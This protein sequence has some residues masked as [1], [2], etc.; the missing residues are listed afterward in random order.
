VGFTGRV[1]VWDGLVATPAGGTDLVRLVRALDDDVEVWHALKLGG[2]LEPWATWAEGA[3]VF[4]GLPPVAVYGGTTTF[5]AEGTALTQLHVAKDRWSA[6]V[7]GEVRDEAPDV[8]ALAARL[9]SAEDERDRAA[10]RRVSR[11]HAER[12]R[13]SLAVLVACTD[14]E[15]GAVIASPTTS[16]PEVVG[17]GRQFD[18]R[19]SWLRDSSVAIT[20]ASLVGNQELAD[21]YVRF[22]TQLGSERIL[23][24]PIRSVDGEL[25]PD[26]RVVPDVEGWGVSQ[27][28]RVG[29]DAAT[30]LQ[31][32]V[33]G[34]VL[35]AIVTVRRTRRRLDRD[36]WDIATQ[37]ADRAAD[38]SAPS[39]GIWEIRDQQDYVSGDIGR[40]LALDRALQLGHRLTGARSRGRW[41]RARNDVRARV[42]GALRDDGSL[43]QIYGRPGVD[44]SALVLVAFD[45]VPARDP[46]AAALVDATIRTL[47]AGPLLY[48]Y[49]PDGRDGFDAGEAPFVPASWW[50]VTAL[51]KLG[52]PDAQNRADELCRMLPV[53]QPEEFD[54][55]RREAL[56]N[57]PLL[58]SH[59]E[60][61]R[62]LF[63]LDRQRG[64][65]RRLR[66]VWRRRR[67]A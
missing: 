54:P 11:T 64:I 17:G 26:E 33:L 38:P 16:L 10:P 5:G 67:F 6:L 60:C 25:V 23:D 1:E 49:P 62:A 24:A 55:A 41:R 51:A 7:V 27:P 61:T 37:L 63:E 28:V 39:N 66:R 8:D 18:Y 46:R 29:N 59:A 43:P 31:Y 20:A 58:W 50:A 48:R 19:Y 36:L 12:V 42:L 57:T 34:F 47:G 35:D 22:L 15:T 21:E 56:G 9:T 2:F 45:L 4:D 52:H 30:Q 14:R 32:D 65:T 40:W 3:A 53:L 13:H 44:A